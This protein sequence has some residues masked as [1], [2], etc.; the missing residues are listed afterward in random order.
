MAAIITKTPVMSQRAVRRS[1]LWREKS[2]PATRPSRGDPLLFL[3][4]RV[5]L[6]KQS[7]NREAC[8]EQAFLP[9]QSVAGQDAGRPSD[10]AGSERMRSISSIVFMT[11]KRAVRVVS[12][13]IMIIVATMP[14]YPPKP[15]ENERTE[16][17]TSE[18]QT[19]MHT[20]Y[21]VY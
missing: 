16:E 1:L 21:A 5:V 19:L 11:V 18:L 2:G 4:G 10:L 12:R 20:S 17:H 6:I 7:I 3:V 15:S 14:R 8:R 13:A 9:R